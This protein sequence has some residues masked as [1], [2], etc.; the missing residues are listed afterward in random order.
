MT[1]IERPAKSIIRRFYDKTLPDPQRVTFRNAAIGLSETPDDEVR[2]EDDGPPPSKK[3]SPSK[4]RSPVKKVSPDRW[5]VL[6]R[7]KDLTETNCFVGPVEKSSALH[8]RLRGSTT[9][10]PKP[11]N[12]ASSANPPRTGSPGPAV[13]GDTVV[14]MVLCQTYHYMIHSGLLCSCVA[15][16]GALIF[17]HVSTEEPEVLFYFPVLFHQDQGRPRQSDQTAVA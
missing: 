1:A 13:K 5:G 11:D 6:V 10:R 15:S 7:E 3:R 16:G 12:T 8:S 9:P 14:A 17:L 4:S 2:V